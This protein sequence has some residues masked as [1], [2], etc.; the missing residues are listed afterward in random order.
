MEAA[1]TTDTMDRVTDLQNQSQVCAHLHPFP[2]DSGAKAT[3]QT[4]SLSLL[5]LIVC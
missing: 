5:C 2:A 3:L 4:Q 1:G